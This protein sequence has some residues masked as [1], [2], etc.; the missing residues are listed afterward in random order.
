LKKLSIF[1]D[2][3]MVCICGWSKN[4]VQQTSTKYLNYLV[5]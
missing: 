2:H 5:W 4:T 1:L 3:N